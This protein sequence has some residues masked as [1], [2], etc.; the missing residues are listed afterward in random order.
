MG[1]PASK[2]PSRRLHLRKE[3]KQM[4]T[5]DF[6]RNALIVY[7]AAIWLAACGASQNSV[8][9][10]TSRGSNLHRAFDLS[11]PGWHGLLSPSI[12]SVYVFTGPPDGALPD[13]GLTNVN[14]IPYGTT[15][16]GGTEC[17]SSV[18]PGEGCGTIFAVAAPGL[19]RV[20]YRFQGGADG[21]FPEADLLDVNNTLYGTTHWGGSA[22]GCGTIFAIT[23]SGKKLWTYGFGTYSASDGSQPEAGLIDVNGVLFGSTLAG[24]TGCNVGCGTIFAATSNGLES[25]IYRFHGGS[26]GANPYAGLINVNGTLYGTTYSGGGRS[27]CSTGCGTIYST[28]TSGSEEVLWRF[29]GGTDGAHPYAGLI[30]VNGTLYGTTFFGGS[31]SQCP[32]GCGTIFAL[33]TNGRTHLYSVIYRFQGGSDGSNPYAGLI[34]VN[35]TL[36]GTTRYGGAHDAGTVFSVTLPSDTEKVIYA[37][38]GGDDG[39]NPNAPLLKIKR[40]LYGTTE[41]GGANL[42]KGNIFSLRP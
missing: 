18:Y 37:F 27:Q 4:K 11:A 3:Q 36:Y 28:T 10:M 16:A 5:S 26:D 35:A 17:G 42:H 1:Q 9:G 31:S 20:V 29:A 22:C 30:N 2:T 7:I 13:A 8:P 14:G 15:L 23:S 21:Y 19:E 38:Q 39:A 12:R 6:I 32:S 41:S 33:T 24:G 40:R 25:V 34:N